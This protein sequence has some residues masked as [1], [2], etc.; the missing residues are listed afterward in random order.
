MKKYSLTG[1]FKNRPK[2]KNL[3]FSKKYKIER[4]ARYRNPLKIKK[5]ILQFKFFRLINLILIII[6]VSSLYF[7]IFSDFYHITNIEIYGN[8]IISTE[9]LLDLTNNFL[10]QK[11]FFVF[12]NKNIFI[13]SRKNL[14]QKIN[15]A[16]LLDD[17]KIEK[18]LP[19]TLRIIINEKE[20]VLKWITD[21]QE[22]LIGKQG[23]I[24][25]RFHKL[26]TPKIFQIGDLA[27]LEDNSYNNDFLKI[28]NLAP[29]PVNLGD[30]VLKQGD[31]EF[32]LNLA[33]EARKSEYLRIK[34]ISVPNIL[35]QYLIIE[36]EGDWKIYFNLADSL[37]NQL[38]RLNILIAEKIKKE[39]LR[40]VDYIDLRLGESVYYKM[41]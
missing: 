36:N 25:K 3:L 12:K 20:A 37:T 18:I 6:I 23:I 8:Q 14:R 7:F 41:K 30:Y 29:E 40:A 21:G 28:D 13:S 17:I 11:R 16:I 27:P 32:I 5:G 39:N 15:Q 9:D 24:I 33:N 4:S 38:N 1:L 35:P 31:I 10:N 34:K 22:Y 19:N 26:K 2:R